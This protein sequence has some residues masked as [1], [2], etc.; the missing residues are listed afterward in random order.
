MIPA[1]HVFSFAKQHFKAFL[2]PSLRKLFD[3]MMQFFV[4]MCAKKFLSI[5]WPLVWRRRF[6]LEHVIWSSL[7]FIFRSLR[8]IILRELVLVPA[9]KILLAINLK[10]L[11]CCYFD[12]LTLTKKSIVEEFLFIVRWCGHKKSSF[13][14]SRCFKILRFIKKFNLPSE[15]ANSF[16]K[17]QEDIHFK[18]SFLFRMPLSARLSGC[19][20]ENTLWIDRITSKFLFWELGKERKKS[21]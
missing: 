20:H 16:D 15:A 2:W 21:N 5:F 7:S 17:Q 11:F 6:V 13:L 10:I 4:V 18:N 12:H 1:F 3:V 19:S 14:F 8:F 9:S